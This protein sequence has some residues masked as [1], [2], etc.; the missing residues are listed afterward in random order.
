MRQI[1]WR[2]RSLW[3]YRIGLTAYFT[4]APILLWGCGWG[5]SILLI[6][7]NLILSTIILPDS[8][9]LQR[10]QSYVKLICGAVATFLFTAIV[11]F[12]IQTRMEKYVYVITLLI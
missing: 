10:Q 7:V 6:C 3:L 4:L 8:I 9:A 12:P 11:F 1:D 5:E 2:D